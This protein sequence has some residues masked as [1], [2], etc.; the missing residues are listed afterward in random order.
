MAPQLTDHEED[1]APTLSLASPSL[2]ELLAQAREELL[3][4]G[5]RHETQRG[6]TRS[7]NGVALTWTDPERDTTD[8]LE[9]TAGEIAW[10]LRV[11]VE[12]RPENDPARRASD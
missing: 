5:V 1:T 10:Y 9:W 2:A 3:T 8:E 12:K 11:F 6:A 4:H 7:L